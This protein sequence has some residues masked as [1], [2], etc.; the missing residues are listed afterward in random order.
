MNNRYSLPHIFSAEGGIQ[1]GKN[2]EKREKWTWFVVYSC[3]SSSGG[4]CRR[5]VL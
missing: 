2:S 3:D 1:L 5:K 4:G